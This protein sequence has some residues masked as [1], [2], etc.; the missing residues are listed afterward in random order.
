MRLST[1]MRNLEKTRMMQYST[2]MSRAERPI[3]I[4]STAATPPL[5]RATRNRLVTAGGLSAV[6]LIL[7]GLAVAKAA[8]HNYQPDRPLIGAPLT[9][10]PLNTPENV[11]ATTPETVQR[12]ENGL[13][14]RP[15]SRETIIITKPPETIIV[16]VPPI[17]VFPTPTSGGETAQ[18]TS[19]P[20]LTTTTTQESQTTAP[21]T[22]SSTEQTTTE[23]TETTSPPTSTITEAPVQ[24]KNEEITTLPEAPTTVTNEG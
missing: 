23:V 13:P 22:S 10:A 18:P 12:D 16:E 4:E 6:V 15:S 1:F 2:R 17:Q 21:T 5:D 11:I 8:E 9:S 24:V 20:E 7:G 3:H 19:T 14:N